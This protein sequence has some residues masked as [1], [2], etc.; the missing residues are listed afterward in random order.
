MGYSDAFKVFIRTDNSIICCYN[1]KTK[2][3]SSYAYYDGNEFCDKQAA[4]KLYDTLLK[5]VD[6][7]R[8]F[9]NSSKLASNELFKTANIRQAL[10]N[11][12]LLFYLYD[13]SKSTVVILRFIYA[14][15]SIAD[16][17]KEISI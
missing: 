14:K 8:S 1:E 2:L 11:N 3:I 17:L 7:V 6:R 15:R 5:V 12:Y 4:K 10:V 13:E 16:L 9:P